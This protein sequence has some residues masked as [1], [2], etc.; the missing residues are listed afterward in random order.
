MA[1]G[2]R[3]SALT[4]V[5]LGTPLHW[6]LLGVFA[7]V[8]RTMGTR[9]LHV[10]AFVPFSLTILALV[11]LALALIVWRYRPGQHVTRESIDESILPHGERE[12][13]EV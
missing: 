12:S 13:D 8:L 11:V 3:G 1:E 2:A 7:I 4:R 6:A 10:R 5:F 9:H